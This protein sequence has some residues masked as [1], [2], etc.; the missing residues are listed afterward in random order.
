MR[1]GSFGNGPCLQECTMD[2]VPPFNEFAVQQEELP[3][4]KF[5]IITETNLLCATIHR[6]FPGM[7]IRSNGEKCSQVS[8]STIYLINIVS[9]NDP[10]QI[11]SVAGKFKMFYFNMA[12]EIMK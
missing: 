9:T 12:F 2:E 3:E 4:L 5:L 10:T 8:L 1:S 7:E 6:H 11:C